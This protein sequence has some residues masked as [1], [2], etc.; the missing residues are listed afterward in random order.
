ML[1]EARKCIKNNLFE[2]QTNDE[3]DNELLQGCMVI[4][5]CVQED[6]RIKNVAI[7]QINTTL[8]Q[9]YKVAKYVRTFLC[10]YS[11]QLCMYIYE[12]IL[13]VHTYIRSYT[14]THTR[15]HT[16]I[17]VLHAITYT[18]VCIVSSYVRICMLYLY[19]TIEI[20]G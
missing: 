12:R 16:H 4:L 2:L 5:S 20:N 9:L 10:T 7:N 13:Y 6:E 8:D 15:T 11:V 18:H 19:Y 3:S 1:D 14:H 17:Y